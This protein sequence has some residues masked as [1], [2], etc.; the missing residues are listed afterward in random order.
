M[1]E[2]WSGFRN[3]SPQHKLVRA[4]AR[5]RAQNQGKQLRGEESIDS[6][7]QTPKGSQA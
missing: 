1:F 6:S 7:T 4:H 3:G 2:G 5:E